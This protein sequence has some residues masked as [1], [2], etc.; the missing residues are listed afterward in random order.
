[1]P[2]ATKIETREQFDKLARAD[3]LVFRPGGE[4]IFPMYA[5]DGAASGGA[6]IC[7]TAEIDGEMRQL[8]FEL[9]VSEAVA[10]TF[11]RPSRDGSAKAA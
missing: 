11:L 4:C 7:L 9:P 3:W 8:N 6:F 5:D 2:N 10:A 1:M